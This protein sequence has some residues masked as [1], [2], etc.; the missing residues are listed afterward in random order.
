MRGLEHRFHALGGPCRFRVECDDE[1]A[2]LAAIASAEAEVA[3]LEARY[4]RYREDSLTSV[5]NRAAGGGEPVAIDA[6]TAG[7]FH[8][9]HTLW[10]QSGGLFDLTSGVLRRAWDFRSGRV[11]AQRELEGLLPLVGWDRVQW[12]PESVYLP[13]PG[14]ELD[15]GGCGKEYAVDAAA[16]VLAGHGMNHAL[17]DLAGDMAVTGPRADGSAWQVG[18]RDPADPQR[19]AA[20][21]ELRAGALASSGNYERCI[22]LDGRRYGHILD[23]R[24][25]WPVAGLVAAS[26]AAPQCLVAGGAATVALLKPR[27]EGRTWLAELGLPWLTWDRDLHCAGSIAPAHA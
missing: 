26:V 4:S 20:R 5:I 16:A 27:D 22:E 25:G 11:P 12:D 19:A 1:P 10:E 17:V 9:A 13:V 3:R 2:A 23:P 7:L 8:F 6:E 24:S 15:F 14:M 18:I 21:V